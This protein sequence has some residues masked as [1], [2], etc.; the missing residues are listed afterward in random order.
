METDKEHH[1]ALV[2]IIEKWKKDDSLP[3]A[4][5]FNIEIAYDKEELKAATEKLLE[6]NLGAKYKKLGE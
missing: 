5:M 6:E 1:K 2:E 4:K 3:I